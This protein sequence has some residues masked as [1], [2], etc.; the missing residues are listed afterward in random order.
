MDQIQQKVN[1][2]YQERIFKLIKYQSKITEYEKQK[3]SSRRMPLEENRQTNVNNQLESVDTEEVDLKNPVEQSGNIQNNKPIEYT[4]KY[5]L[6]DLIE[7]AQKR[8]KQRNFCFQ[9]CYLFVTSLKLYFKNK[10]FVFMSTV[11]LFVMNG[12]IMLLYIDL[13]DIDVDTYTAI[14]NRQGFFFIA[15]VM[16]FFT[17]ANATL[18]SLLPKKKLYIKDQ[19]GRYYS[20]FAFY[21]SQQIVNIPLFAVSLLLVCLA[22]YYGLGLNSSPD[23]STFFTF[24]Y[25]I[26]IGANL[27]GASLGFLIASI[28]PDMETASMLIPVMVLPLMLCN[29]FFG[30]LKDASFLI[31]GISYLSPPKFFYQ[32]LTLNEFRNYQEY[33]DKCSL[34]VPCPPNSNEETCYQ[35]TSNIICDPLATAD[36]F[37]DEI[38]L[39]ILF[40][41]VLILFYR[42][43]GYLLFILINRQKVLKTK[44]NPDMRK[45]IKTFMDQ[46]NFVD[47]NES[48]AQ[49]LNESRMRDSII[50]DNP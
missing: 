6:S 37:E 31:T 32:G 33:I 41:G 29:G 50:Q 30:N 15:S 20:S 4:K 35:K 46:A 2:V 43:F 18:M 12:I 39:N 1:D 5:D 22:F 24:Y 9:L 23:I 3:W 38:W 44:D 28:A 34:P 47:L 27:G 11:F 48:I 8:N 17:G 45:Q 25:F 21:L 49:E 14:T 42:I 10:I 36:Y 7:Y 26:F 16:A 19:H 13:G 40:I